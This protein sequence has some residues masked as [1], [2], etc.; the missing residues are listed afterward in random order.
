[1]INIP[2]APK[3]EPPPKGFP[4]PVPDIALC[5]LPGLW[6]VWPFLCNAFRLFKKPNGLVFVLKNEEVAYFLN[7]FSPARI[8]P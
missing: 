6:P 7:Y 3:I 2:A 8:K 4:L 5:A 1:M